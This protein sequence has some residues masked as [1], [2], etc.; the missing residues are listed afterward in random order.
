MDNVLEIPLKKEILPVP[1]ATLEEGD[2]ES[3]DSQQTSYASPSV[4]RFLNFSKDFVEELERLLR[5]KHLFFSKTS[6]FQCIK[7]LE[8]GILGAWSLLWSSRYQSRITDI[9]GNC[10]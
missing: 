5:N 3:E 2:N 4:P 8:K 9:W 10:M 6:G 7:T 1:D